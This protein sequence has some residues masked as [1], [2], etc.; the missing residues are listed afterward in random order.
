MTHPFEIEL[1]ATL[2][3]SPEEVWEAIATGP[4]IDSWVMGRNE[5]EPRVGGAAAMDTGG[6]RAEAVVTAYE[7]GKRFAIRGTT[8]EDGQFMAFEYLIEGRDRGSTVLRVVHSGML[9]DDWRDEYDAL[10][11]GWPFHLH[12]LREYLT[13]VPGRAGVP[14]FAV[15]Q[16]GGKT[17][18]EVRAALAGALSLPAPVTVGARAHAVLTNTGPA[19]LPPLAGEVTW[20]DDER[21]AVRGADGL[22]SFHSGGGLVLMFHHL[23]PPVTAEDT[24]KNTAADT[25]DGTE[26]TGAEAAWQHWLTALLAS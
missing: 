22:Y 5:V 17:A 19:G 6:H 25:A 2:P 3:A 16:S 15:A 24:A 7:P 21:F 8:A 12:T 9:G 18:Q 1:E 20:A 4:G 11:R 10:R 26:S 13:D 14:V 23:F